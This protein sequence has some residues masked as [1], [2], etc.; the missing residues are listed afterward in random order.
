MNTMIA[1]VV[2]TLLV[3]EHPKWSEEVNEPLVSEENLGV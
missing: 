1:K 2:D 3:E